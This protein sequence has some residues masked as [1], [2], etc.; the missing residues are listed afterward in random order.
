ML[1]N[2]S[3]R[4]LKLFFFSC[5]SFYAPD[6]PFSN[7]LAEISD[8][9][10]CSLCFKVTLQVLS[11]NLQE[12]TNMMVFILE[13]GLEICENSLG[14]PQQKG[15]DFKQVFGGMLQERVT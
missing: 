4:P 5:L 1:L 6:G 7:G 11:F 13:N 15:A 9:F 14:V 8:L 2:D 12:A 3:I 10:L